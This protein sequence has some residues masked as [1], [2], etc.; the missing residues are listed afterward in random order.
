M[1]EKVNHVKAQSLQHLERAKWIRYKIQN[2]DET[3]FK[4]IYTIGKCVPLR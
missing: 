4:I 2:F 3:I 1:E